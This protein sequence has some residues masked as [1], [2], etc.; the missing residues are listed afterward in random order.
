MIAGRRLLVV[1]SAVLLV[2]PAVLAC[3][4]SPSVKSTPT[5]RTATALDNFVK[6]DQF[7]GTVLVAMTALARLL[8]RMSPRVRGTV[9]VVLV[10]FQ[11]AGGVLG[12]RAWR[13]GQAPP[14]GSHGP[15]GSGPT[16]L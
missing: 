6:L 13:A 16:A 3:G 2:A 11:A 9:V 4:S 8:H 1:V 12:F 10:L 14:V 15:S 7:N 5:S